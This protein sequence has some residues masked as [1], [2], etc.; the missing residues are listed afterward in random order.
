M[1]GSKRRR[2]RKGP[3]QPSDAG[4]LSTAAG[5]DQEFAPLEEMQ[6]FLGTPLADL[7]GTAEAQAELEELT[8]Q[9]AAAPAIAR[10]REVVAFVGNG[11]AGTQAG[12]LT[13]ADAVA[14]TERLA[15]GERVPRD[16]RSI[17]DVP[18]T[19]RAFRWAAAAG[20][21]ARR[22]TEIVPG[23]LASELERDPL[24]AWITAAVILLEH[25]VLDGFQ[26]WRKSYVELLDS[27]APALIVA[28]A[29]A[30]GRVPLAA[31]DDSAWEQ[32]AAV[33]GYEPDDG[34]E[35]AHVV[36]LV[37]AIVGEFAELGL[38]GLHDGE[39]ELTDLGRVLAALIA[40]NGDDDAEDDLDLVDTDAQSLLLVCAEEMEP[41]DARAHLLAWCDGRPADEAAA[42]LCEAMLD[43]D[44]QDVWQLGL[45]ALTM[46]DRAE[47]EAAVRRLRSHPGLR[48]L[49]DGWLRRHG[50]A[51]TSPPGTGSRASRGRRT[52]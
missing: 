34:A 33:Y 25:G 27:G 36:G 2:A 9:A 8:R 7:V 16:V 29:Q 20:F 43:D 14:L 46:I 23:P 21:L 37:R 48:P 45:E 13:V 44:D 4:L 11:R 47:A 51:P 50:R 26:G 3:R 18:E 30:G 19:A 38:A 40:L 41:A 15:T 12:N 52:P 1:A 17:D 10:L 49:A 24:A 28:V 42:E 32:V 5:A 31:V 22:G 39:L 6:S 35:R